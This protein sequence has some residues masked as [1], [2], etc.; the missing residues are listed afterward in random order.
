MDYSDDNGMLYIESGE[1][2]LYSDH[3][4]ESDYG[5]DEDMH[6]DSTSTRSQISYV[7]LKEEDIREHQK[8]DIE[9]VSTVLSID[10]VK[11]IILLLHYRWSSSKVE[12]E[13]FTDE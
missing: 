12:D 8:A 3:T 7:V 11:A 5:M 6:N 9:Q 13:W 4:S 2:N 1:E 10:Q